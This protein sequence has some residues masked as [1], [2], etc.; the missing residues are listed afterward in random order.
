MLVEERRQKVIDLVSERAY[1][2]R[3]GKPSDLIPL[4]GGFWDA[5]GPT[6]TSLIEKLADFD[7]ELL[8]KLLEEVENY[9]LAAAVA[10]IDEFG[11]P[12]NFG[13]HP[14]PAYGCV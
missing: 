2:Y 11:I 10:K 5:E 1:R 8:E 6:R 9:D 13:S 14:A 7:D 12:F 3:P 4:P